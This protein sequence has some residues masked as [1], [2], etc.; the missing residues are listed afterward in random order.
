MG[1][2]SARSG[3]CGVRS[4]PRHPYRTVSADHPSILSPATTWLLCCGSLVSRKK[5][6]IESSRPEIEL[7]TRRLSVI[8]HRRARH[9]SRHCVG[10]SSTT[11]DPTI[12]RTEECVT[13]RSPHRAA[14]HDRSDHRSHST[15]C[16]ANRRIA[17]PTRKRWTDALSGTVRCPS[18]P[19]RP[20]A[21]RSCRGSR[22]RHA[23]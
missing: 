4:R 14:T 2:R 1:S 12:V 10:R 19:R 16:L 15:H 20:R 5:R 17:S 18:C 6:T 7:R 22:P 13:H 21:R 23:P 8:S 3:P 9:H 11:S